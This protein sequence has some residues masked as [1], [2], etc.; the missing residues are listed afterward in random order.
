MDAKGC[1]ALDSACVSFDTGIF[2]NLISNSFI[3]VLP[4]PSSG[5]F[6]I[7]FPTDATKNVEIMDAL[8]K[9]IQKSETSSRSIAIDISGYADGIYYAR[10]VSGKD[11]S[12]VKLMKE[13]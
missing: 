10:I 4:N 2:T 6:L 7:Q 11:L 13:K 1:V 12:V 3:K 9:V 8:G 5:K